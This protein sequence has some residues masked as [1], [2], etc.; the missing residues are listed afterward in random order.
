MSHPT[1]YLNIDR[2]GCNRKDEEVCYE[3][4]VPGG[5][6]VRV[7]W[8]KG[9]W[10]LV[11]PFE[12][13]TSHDEGP[14]VTNKQTHALRVYIDKEHFRSKKPSTHKDKVPLVSER[15]MCA[16]PIEIGR[17]PMNP[18]SRSATHINLY[19]AMTDTPVAFGMNVYSLESTSSSNNKR[20]VWS[21]TSAAVV[22]WSHLI[23]T[24]PNP[25]AFKTFMWSDIRMNTN[26]VG[27]SELLIVHS[28]DVV[29]YETNRRDLAADVKTVNA[30]VFKEEFDAFA[31]LEFSP[32]TLKKLRNGEEQM[33]VRNS[34]FNTTLDGLSYS[35]PGETFGGDN[36][37]E[38]FMGSSAQSWY[39]YDKP[40]VTMDWLIQKLAQVSFLH[41]NNVETSFVNDVANI[42]TGNWKDEQKAQKLLTDVVRICTMHATSTPYV[43]DEREDPTTGKKKDSDLYCSALKV[44]GDCEDGAHSA[45]MIYMSILFHD[46]AS[47][48]IPEG[49]TAKDRQ[50]IVA[51]QK[52][53]AY[54]GFPICI[55]GT[56]ANPM[57]PSSA[58]GTHAYGC[59]IPF[60]RFVKALFG[61]SLSAE[62]EKAVYH[63]F[64]TKFNYEY[65]R[66]TDPL[67]VS[68][69]ET[70]LFST[71][72]VGHHLHPE[73][74]HEKY[75]ILRKFAMEEMGEHHCAAINFMYTFVL[76][77]DC[78][79][80][81]MA[82]KGFTTAH[83]ELFYSDSAPLTL[84]PRLMDG[85]M[86][87][88][89][90]S[91][92]FAFWRPGGYIGVHRD[93]LYHMEND[94]GWEL[95]V[96][97]EMDGATWESDTTLIQSCR[98]P[99]QALVA[100][101]VDPQKSNDVNAL[102][103]AKYMDWFRYDEPHIMVFVYDAM[104]K[105]P[106]GK[107]VGEKMKELA[108]ALGARKY[109]TSLYDK[110]LVIIFTEF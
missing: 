109:V 32:D 95:R 5:D 71:P 80:H 92:T 104:Y 35:V 14:P 100:R 55:T 7:V 102:L 58:G 84:H 51:L 19:T 69:I 63:A 98:A 20:K 1:V 79:C 85:T 27:M 49:K 2:A 76:D 62:D 59:I 96:P 87:R 89:S 97:V 82:I 45:Y 81:L 65:P 75:K 36:M 12:T 108:Q 105:Y 11:H 110:C 34:T 74:E 60:P 66:D 4:W 53:A 106:D 93:E 37:P 48:R 28:M 9:E 44:P 38:E 23:K 56:A 6:C 10:T 83:R 41:S 52:L 70:T 94:C 3:I 107:S 15:G 16:D 22:P 103:A 42:I 99:F 18:D 30:Y 25:I 26:V 78:A 33:A 31:K 39:Y 57:K 64:K 24:C 68:A 67:E 61:S 29:R 43:P 21:W 50:N 90:Y 86:C 101:V 77:D 40:V 73:I 54:L 8:H 91:C 47:E 13:W 17:A 88:E 46:W 72:L